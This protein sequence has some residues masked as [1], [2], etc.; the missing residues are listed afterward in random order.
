M[1]YGL[2]GALLIGMV[3]LAFWG[4]KKNQEKIQLVKELHEKAVREKEAIE[5]G[6]Q[7]DDLAGLASDS[8][9]RVRERMRKIMSKLMPMSKKRMP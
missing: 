5:Y 6:K 8:R 2:I 7:V 3:A 9:L 1:G 4:G